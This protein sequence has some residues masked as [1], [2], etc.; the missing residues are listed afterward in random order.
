MELEQIAK[1]FCDKKGI[2]TPVS[3]HD[4]LQVALACGYIDA[5]TMVFFKE[6]YGLPLDM[7]LMQMRKKF[8]HIKV[9]YSGLEHELLMIGT[10]DSA[11]KSQIE[12]LRTADRE[13]PL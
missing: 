5:R 1:D 4:R 10:N 9:D 6:T 3:L 13:I 2:K 11:V 12:E 7:M 8:P